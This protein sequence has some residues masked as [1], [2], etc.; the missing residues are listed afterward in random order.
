MSVV[1]NLEAIRVQFVEHQPRIAYALIIFVGSGLTVQ[2][3]PKIFE[4]FLST[5]C[6]G[7]GK[8]IARAKAQRTPSS[9]KSY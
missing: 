1:T 7:I 8:K 3:Y 5:C 6:Y 4:I 2:S 9:E